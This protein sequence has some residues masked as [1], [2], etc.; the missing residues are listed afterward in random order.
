MY[1]EPSLEFDRYFDIPL[2]IVTKHELGIPFP[3]R[4]LPVKLGTNPSTIFLVIVV[5]DR[6]THTQT[7]AGK[8][9]LPRFRGDKNRCSSDHQ[10]SHINITRCVL[11]W[12]PIYFGVR[13]LS[14]QGTKTVPAW[15]FVLLLVLA[16]LPMW[17]CG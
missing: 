17:P 14:S 10:T 3:P 15:I 2:P 6:Q 1:S 12:K 8:N 16:N 5:T 13:R 4:N 7:N 9:I 11:T